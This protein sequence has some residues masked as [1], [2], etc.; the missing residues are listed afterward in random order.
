MIVIESISS[1][2]SGVRR[3]WH[4]AERTG[5]IEIAG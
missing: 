3:R 5:E 1:A 2:L 4:R